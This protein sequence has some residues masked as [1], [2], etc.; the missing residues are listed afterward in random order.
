MEKF[1]ISVSTNI[2]APRATIQEA[3]ANVMQSQTGAMMA[4]FEASV[5]VQKQILEAV[6]GIQ[7]G[8]DMIANACDRYH[9]KLAVMRGG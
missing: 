4:G 7:I 8:D 1:R 6:L 3:V 9:R 2:E 5:Q